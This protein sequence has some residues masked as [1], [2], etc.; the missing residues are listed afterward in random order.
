MKTHQIN[1]RTCKSA[2]DLK[3]QSS[4][5][6]KE[7]Q[8]FNSSY[9]IDPNATIELNKLCLFFKKS[10]SAGY[11]QIRHFAFMLFYYVCQLYAALVL[12]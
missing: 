11:F 10:K 7:R 3:V 4:F 6:T 8:G 1:E 2:E 9:Q 12:L 5:I